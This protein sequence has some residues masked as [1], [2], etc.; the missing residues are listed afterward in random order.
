MDSATPEI[1]SKLSEVK[2]TV[3]NGSASIAGASDGTGQK[4]KKNIVGGTEDIPMAMAGP[5]DKTKT[6]IERLLK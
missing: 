6:V 1:G 5:L 4:V 3:Q 2:N